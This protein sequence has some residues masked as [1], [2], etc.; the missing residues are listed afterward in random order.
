VNITAEAKQQQYTASCLEIL[1]FLGRDPSLCSRIDKLLPAG[2]V[3]SYNMKNWRDDC[4]VDVAVLERNSSLCVHAVSEKNCL[5]L[6]AEKV[7]YEE[8]SIAGHRRQ[9][10][11]N[12]LLAAGIFIVILGI[13]S[14]YYLQIHRRKDRPLHHLTIIG[15]IAWVL[16]LCIVGFMF[17][18]SIPD[19]ASGHEA[20][21]AVLMLYN[22]VIGV[23]VLFGP[24]I[25][26]GALMLFKKPSSPS[27]SEQP[28]KRN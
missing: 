26:F 13:S 6:Y 16:Y 24:F 10:F 7:S 12:A 14:A 27:L 18:A 22:I 11:W 3:P 19:G 4:V 8:Q 23:S 20:G 21:L 2:E 5:H 17:W 28:E 9:T 25:I 15:G 1:A